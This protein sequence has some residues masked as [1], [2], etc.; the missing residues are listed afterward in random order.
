MCSNRQWEY[1]ESFEQLTDIITESMQTGSVC[2]LAEPCIRSRSFQQN[3]PYMV[4]NDQADYS[5]QT[6]GTPF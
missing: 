3:Q 6:L 2:D 4:F 5:G 1:G